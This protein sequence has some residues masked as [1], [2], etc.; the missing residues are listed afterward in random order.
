M[1]DLE[2]KSGTIEVSDASFPTD[3]LSSKK[4][5][6]VVRLPKDV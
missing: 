1:S 5:V 6:L 2:K 4:P 3:V